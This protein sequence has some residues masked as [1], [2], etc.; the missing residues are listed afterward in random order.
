MEFLKASAAAFIAVFAADLL[1]KG[2][3]L[4][5]LLSTRRSPAA[6]FLGAACAMLASCCLW[7]FAGAAAGALLH[8]R[9]VRFVAGAALVGA[10][11]MLLVFGYDEAR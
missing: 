2:T 6:V 7:I 5:G 3:L 4:T 11:L 9:W 1:D 8:A 10:G